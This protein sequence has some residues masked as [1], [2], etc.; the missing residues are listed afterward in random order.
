MALTLWITGLSL[1]WSIIAIKT[2]LHQFEMHDAVVVNGTTEETKYEKRIALFIEDN[3][4]YAI[5]T[6][7]KIQIKHSD[8]D[9][10]I[11]YLHQCCKIT[12]HSLSSFTVEESKSST[13]VLTDLDRQKLK[14]TFHAHL[15]FMSEPHYTSNTFNTS[16]WLLLN[17][18]PNHAFTNAFY[19]YIVHNFGVNALYYLSSNYFEHEP[20]LGLHFAEFYQ[21]YLRFKHCSFAKS[22]NVN[23][24]DSGDLAKIKTLKPQ[25]NA[26][27]QMKAQHFEGSFGEISIFAS[28]DVTR[29]NSRN[30]TEFPIQSLFEKDMKLALRPKYFCK[31]AKIHVHKLWHDAC[32]K[33]P[34][35]W[36]DDSNA[37]LY[38][39]YFWNWNQ[40][41]GIVPLS[42]F[43]S[44]IFAMNN[45][46]KENVNIDPVTSACFIFIDMMKESN[47]LIQTVFASLPFCMDRIN[48]DR[49][50]K[51]IE[52]MRKSSKAKEKNFLEGIKKLFDS[53]N[54][55]MK[56]ADIS[57]T[58]NIT[59]KGPSCVCHPQ[60][61]QSKCQRT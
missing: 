32:F 15:S 11:D 47:N 12:N 52:K 33:Q 28:G 27:L 54:Y 17:S 2:A 26:I 5:V 1:I 20:Q 14:M 37:V 38:L 51:V 8:K 42:D 45:Q 35:L 41:K 3:D 55:K 25:K 24:V 40:M 48:W 58:S 22:A 43:Q 6:I 31:I 44:L 53:H 49:I 59:I 16:F 10:R 39:P 21:K 57:L 9:S 13:P 4:D 18:I 7:L 60:L 29:K 50:M 46:G 61:S 23:S 30:Q 56:N 19:A 36:R 34:E